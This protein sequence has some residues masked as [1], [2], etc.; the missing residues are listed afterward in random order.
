VFGAFRGLVKEALSLAFW[1]GAAVL[2]SLLDDTVATQ[3]G[4][5]VAN[6]TARRM[7]AFV[8]I[9]VVTV[10]AGGLISNLLSKLTSRAGLGGT[11][12]MLGALFGI[13]RGV[14]IVTVVVMLTA[15]LEVALIREAYGESF[16]VPY[17]MMLAGM[18]QDMFGLTTSESLA[19]AVFS[20]VVAC[21]A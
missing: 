5:L 14:V 12:R 8:L 4:E 17:I 1:I 20:G 16:L 10:F 18:F 6:P 2:A 11:D 19:T 7:T 15:Q 3:L 21:V 9:F 13:I